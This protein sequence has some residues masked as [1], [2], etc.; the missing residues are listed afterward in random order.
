MTAYSLAVCPSNAT[1]S[2]IGNTALYASPLIGSAQTL[3]RQGLKWHFIYQYDN[4][5]GETRA[6]LM[7]LI[8]HQRGQ[9]NRLRVTV[10]DNPAR[11]LYGGTPVVAGG[12]QTGYTL[13][14]DG[15]SAGVTGWIEYGDYFSV[16]VN[17]EPELKMA[18]APANSS[19]G[20]TVSL[21]FVPR[22]RES[23][24]DN[25]AIYIAGGANEPQGIFLL[26][27]PEAPWQSRPNVSGPI[28]NFTFDMIEDVFATQA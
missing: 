25:A 1:I 26:A 24:A 28:S 16:I 8:A 19:G 14:I 11:G 3:D 2:L 6:Q 27:N 20:G 10:F 21:E 12:G 4:A 23:P 5:S 9:A 13:N 15:A 18:T 17:G 7:S 22:L